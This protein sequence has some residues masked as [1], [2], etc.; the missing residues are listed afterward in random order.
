MKYSICRIASNAEKYK[1]NIFKTF[2]N[3]FD[4]S[5]EYQTVLYY[6]AAELEFLNSRLGIAIIT[7]RSYTFSNILFYRFYKQNFADLTYRSVV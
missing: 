5:R 3:V 1:D 4:G 2:Q 6:S 7:F